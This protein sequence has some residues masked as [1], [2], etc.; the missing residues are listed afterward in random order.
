MTSATRS[1]SKVL[2]F[3][4]S[5]TVGERLIHPEVERWMARASATLGVLELNEGRGGRP[6]SAL[7]EFRTILD[8]SSGNPQIVQLVIA[9]G[10]NDARSDAPDVAATT[11]KNVRQ[12]IEWTRI[13]APT[14]NIVV[15]SP[16]NIN[17]AYLERKEIADLRERNLL[18]IGKALQ[19]VAEKNGCRYVDFLKS[20]P[21]ESL[22]EDG[23]HPN[24]LGHAALAATFIAKY[25][26]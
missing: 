8:A 19:K 21:P 17:R 13:A 12:I 11:A 4:D 2:Y 5:I 18:E 3:G 22:T 20:L 7:D 16:Y 15:C 6:S 10:A 1:H 25:C 9:L 26:G 24:T 14:W 23:V